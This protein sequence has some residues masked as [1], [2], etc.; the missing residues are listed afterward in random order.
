MPNETKLPGKVDR[1]GSFMNCHK[2]TYRTHNRN[3]DSPSDRGELLGFRCVYPI[4]K[5]PLTGLRVLLGGS[6]NNNR[7]DLFRAHFR[8]GD[9]LIGRY[10]TLGFRC[11]YLVKS[12]D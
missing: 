10:Y 2:Y 8:S 1:G 3:W 5:E 12:N 7:S 9:S 11:V 6:W 4:D